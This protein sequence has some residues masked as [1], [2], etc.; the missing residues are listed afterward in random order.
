MNAGAS[1]DTE[2]NNLAFGLSALGG[3][4]AGGENNVAIGNYAADAL[5]SSDHNVMVGYNAGTDITGG[6]SIEGQNALFGNYAG[7]NI[8]NGYQ[9]TC[10]G[11]QSAAGEGDGVG[12]DGVDGNADDSVGYVDSVDGTVS[13]TVT[14]KRANNGVVV[15]APS[16][17]AVS[18]L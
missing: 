16:Y 3:S 8:T 9:N 10:L 7:A 12:A 6:G 13:S 15:T 17:T 14:T 11:Y 5:T 2:S 1:F 18:N 4:V